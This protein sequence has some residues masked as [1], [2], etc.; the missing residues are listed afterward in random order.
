MQHPWP[1]NGVSFS[2]C[3]HTG[4]FRWCCQSC[5]TDCITLLLQDRFTATQKLV[6]PDI[7]L[8]SQLT[9]DASRISCSV[10]IFARPASRD[11]R[12]SS[13]LRWVFGEQMCLA[14]TFHCFHSN[15]KMTVGVASS[16]ARS[17]C[18]QTDGFN[19]NSRNLR[20]L[21]VAKRA[22]IN[23]PLWLMIDLASLEYNLHK[24]LLFSL[25]W[26]KSLTHS[27]KNKCNVNINKCILTDKHHLQKSTRLNKDNDIWGII[28]WW[29]HPHASYC[30]EGGKNDVSTANQ[31][32]Q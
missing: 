30:P 28:H 24:L 7:L 15:K 11:T 13:V 22:E 19:L 12:D 26:R 5:E 8:I 17:R 6:L 10:L 32:H 21:S 31:Q 9:A 4:P 3:P 27:D 20:C 1:R 25:Y 29:T 18:F 23:F 14:S 2:L 16:R